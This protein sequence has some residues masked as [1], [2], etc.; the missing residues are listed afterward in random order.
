MILGEASDYDS[1]VAVMETLEKINPWL[2]GMTLG[3]PRW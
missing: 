3:T 1:A 2:S